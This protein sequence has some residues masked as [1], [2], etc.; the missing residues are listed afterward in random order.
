[1]GTAVGHNRYMKRRTLWINLGLTV[2]LLAVLALVFMALRPG[3]PDAPARTVTAEPGTVTATVTASGTVGHSGSVALAFGAV[4]TVT[5][6]F[7]E[8]GD[9]VTAGEV[10]AEIDPTVAL[11]QLASAESSLASALSASNSSSAAVASAQRGL[12]NTAKTAEESNARN[13][14]AVTQ[15]K[16]NLRAAEATF[17]DECLNTSDPNCPN[18]AAQAALRAAET[19]AA[20]AQANVDAAIAS[21]N[22]NLIGYNVKV[23]QTQASLNKAQADRDASCDPAGTATCRAADST[24]LSAQQAYENALNARTAGQAADQQAIVSA[25]NALASANVAVQKAQADLRKAYN[26]S[27]RTA[28][29]AVT[30]AK[31]AFELG[32]ISGQQSVNQ[33]QASL[34]SAL[35]ATSSVELPNGQEIS[36]SQASIQAA[37]TAVTAAQQAIAETKIIAPFSGIVGSIS[38][39]AGESSAGGT[40]A[41]A[42][43][44]TPGI[45]LL[46]NDGLEVSASFAE[47]DAARVNVGDSATVTFAALGDE[48]VEATVVSIDPVATTGTNALVTY[49]IRVALIDAPTTVR[50]GMTASVT[51]TVANV[52]GVLVL[53]QS[54]IIERG[55]EAFVQVPAEDGTSTEVPVTLGLKGDRGVEVTSGVSAG[56]VVIVPET[57]TSASSGDFPQGGIPGSG[58]NR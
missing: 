18:P 29:Q 6:V 12:A 41:A 3:S 32:V 33:A 19:S 2:G 8:A 30:N 34:D 56:D 50:E 43:T 15:A 14:Q 38:Y 25:T 44:A 5:E 45:T 52:R 53:P 49:G 47:A 22:S 35:A 20:T 36:P 40:S 28:K 7:V 42:S 46:P 37:E 57:D 39:V 21:A 24:L 55:G 51:I 58:N 11:Q 16:A 4:G 17:A 48:T 26:D 31:Q 54:V 13:K 1:M 27:V 9:A 10:L 23:N